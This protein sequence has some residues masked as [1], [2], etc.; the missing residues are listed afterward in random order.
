MLIFKKVRL[1]NQPV[2]FCKYIRLED[3]VET[4][5]FF[6]IFYRDRRM[7][8]TDWFEI[9]LKLFTVSL[10]KDFQEKHSNVKDSSG[11]SVNSRQNL[12]IDHHFVITSNFYRPETKLQESNVFSR[13]CLFRAPALNHHTETPM[14]RVPA[15]PTIIQGPLCLSTAL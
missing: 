13:V 5:E 4:F 7:A 9:T 14:A 8:T 6:T 1:L 11:R 15:C 12:T 3:F 2:S 10:L